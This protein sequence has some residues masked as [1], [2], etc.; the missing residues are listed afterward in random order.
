MI[1]TGMSCR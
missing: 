1:A